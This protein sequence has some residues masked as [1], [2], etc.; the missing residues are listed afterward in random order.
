[1]FHTSSGH[2][3]SRTAAT[4]CALVVLVAS[5]RPAAAQQPSCLPDDGR[6][7]YLCDPLTAGSEP[8]TVAER[9]GGRFVPDGWEVTAFESY[10]LY[11]LGEAVHAGTLSFWMRNVTPAGM[12]ESHLEGVSQKFVFA[13]MQDLPA[14][15]HYFAMIRTWGPWS[16]IYGWLKVK[17]GS[18]VEGEC[19]A[20]PFAHAADWQAERWYHVEMEYGDGHMALRLNGRVIGAFDYGCPYALRYLYVPHLPELRGWL[21]SVHDVVYSHV[22]FTGG[23]IRMDPEPDPP[24]LW[25]DLPAEDE[26]VS[27]VVRVAGWATDASGV[28]EVSLSLDGAPLDVPNLQYGRARADV[29]AD[30]A[31]L[32][33]PGCPN[34]GWFGDADSRGWAPGRHV[35]RAT[36]RDPH[37]NQAAVERAFRV[38]NEVGPGE[39]LGPPDPDLGPPA[40]DVGPIDRDAGTE[41]PDM[42]TPEVDLGP[43]VRDAGWPPADLGS[44]FP[45][46]A[47]PPRDA[48]QPGFDAGATP[49]EPEPGEESVKG[50]GCS[51]AAPPAAPA[52]APGWLWS[53]L[54]AA[55][56]P[57]R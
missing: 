48:T 3:R 18:R 36:A 21:D 25:I 13:R 40:A 4:L 52:E 55:L 37:G 1:M 27:G 35:L 12:H 20:E 38:H 11:D 28:S 24:R 50:G 23:P 41:P 46:V 8:R 29:C 22:S 26:L 34:V 44:S 5:A 10:L 42:G 53:H 15:D 56:C 17:A 43:P 57:A 6:V 16:D 31:E 51:L 7:V 33:D 49:A 47:L 32:G 39:D 54:A 45:D 2:A 19:L 9:H 30:H 14:N